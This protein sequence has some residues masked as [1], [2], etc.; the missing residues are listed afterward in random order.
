MGRSPRSIRK[1]VIPIL[2][3]FD[4]IIDIEG[5]NV[6]DLLN[7]NNIGTFGDLSGLSQHQEEELLE[8]YAD[9]Y[10]DSGDNF[11]SMMNLT[12]N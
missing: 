10:Y 5:D 7:R 6:S 8:D 12:Y 11:G 3:E 4:L 9:E 2:R 1:T